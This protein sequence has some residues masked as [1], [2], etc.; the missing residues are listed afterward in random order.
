MAVGSVAASAPVQRAGWR[1]SNRQQ[2]LLGALLVLALLPV[3][4]RMEPRNFAPFTEVGIWRF[5]GEGV[6]IVLVV[7]TVAILLSLPFALLLA[8]GR[9]SPRLPIR[10]PCIVF[11]EGIRALPL[12]LV[13]FYVF[14]V[15]P[16]DV[17]VFWSR[18][19]LALTLA[20]LTYTAAI[21]AETLRAGILALDRGQT[22]A[23]RSLGLTYFQALR[24]VV[25]P[26]VF[27]STR[28]TLIAQFTTLVKDTSLGSIIAMVE[29]LQ[30]GVIIYQ[31]FRNPMETLYVIG[32]VYFALNFVLEQ[33]SL[34][35]QSRSVAATTGKYL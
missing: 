7:S 16:R 18:E 3:V 15:L 2:S 19:T 8:L 31:G 12:L 11:I 5:I 32:L 23:A 10:G 27:R 6:L 33:V 25:L 1:P 24:W 9:L 14:L 34:A 17:P 30:R 20:L 22:E 35:T 28:P 26:Q 13:I 29:L 21:N 4:F